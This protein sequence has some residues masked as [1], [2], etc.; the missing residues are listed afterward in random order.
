MPGMSTANWEEIAQGP[1]YISGTSVSLG[2]GSRVWTITLSDIGD[3][4]TGRRG[5]QTGD[6]VRA[7][8]I[9]N[10][11]L[12]E[13]LV[14]ANDATTVTVNVLTSSGGGGP[15]SNWL[16]IINPAPNAIRTSNIATNA[17]YYPIFVDAANASPTPE[18]VH[19]DADYNYNPS[20]NVLVSPTMQSRFQN[21]T[22]AC[23]SSS[24]DADVTVD[25]SIYNMARI[26]LTTSTTTRNINIVNLTQ[27]RI[28]E[29]FVTNTHTAGKIFNITVNTTGTAG[30]TSNVY[31]TKKG[32]ALG[33]VRSD[34]LNVATL[35]ANTGYAYVRVANITGS[36]P[37]D[38]VVG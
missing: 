22:A 30:S 27:G 23:L 34:G 25:A 2:T 19:T 14:T 24:G 38:G 36:L 37:A 5:I 35:A 18:Q 26:V 4:S 21:T 29:L 20:T 11:S 16:I 15:F 28:V 9:D 32:A 7:I 3:G 17:T 8:A 12:L 10:G 31:L 1:Y 6:T 33:A 13:G